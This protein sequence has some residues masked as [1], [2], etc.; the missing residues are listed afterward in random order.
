MVFHD[1]VFV[2]DLVVEG[3]LNDVSVEEMLA[4]IIYEDSINVTFAR[5]S[6]EHVTMD[7]DL[8]IAS[9]KIGDVD[10]VALNSSIVRLDGDVTV[11]GFFNFSMVSCSLKQNDFI[12]LTLIY[13][14]LNWNKVLEWIS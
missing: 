3:D 9:N 13:R 6:F 1:G 4:S 8:E 2:Q 7:G 12:I 10:I 5:A 11:T 14:M